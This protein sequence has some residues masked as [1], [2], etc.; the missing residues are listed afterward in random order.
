MVLS[1][2]PTVDG[3]EAGGLLLC[4]YLCM[5]LPRLGFLAPRLWDQREQ[6]HRGAAVEMTALRTASSL[7]RAH[8]S[9]QAQLSYYFCTFLFQTGSHVAR[10]SL[11][12]PCV[13]RGD[14][15]VLMFVLPPPSLDSPGCWRKAL[16]VS[17]FSY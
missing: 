4:L 7:C 8:C 13:T 6:Q 14:L 5:K 9:V 15:E 12:T 10:D 17:G 2:S 1:R 11:A 3:R 16:G